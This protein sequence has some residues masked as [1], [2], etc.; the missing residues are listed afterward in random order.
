[1]PRPEQI[2]PFLEVEPHMTVDHTS[3]RPVDLADPAGL[4]MLVPFGRDPEGDLTMLDALRD[5]L[6]RSGPRGAHAALD[7][8]FRYALQLLGEDA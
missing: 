1:V 6:A 3:I 2:S 8:R 4:G 5:E 7:D